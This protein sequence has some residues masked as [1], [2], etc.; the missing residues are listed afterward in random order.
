MKYY[1]FNCQVEPT[2]EEVGGK[3]KSLIELTK[4]GFEVPKGAVL[5][6]DFFNEW[7]DELR[8]G[9]TSALTWTD[10]ESFPELADRLKRKAED[11]EFS[12]EQ[13]TVIS[14]VI[15]ELDGGGLFAVRSSSPEEDMAGASFAGGY[16]TVLGV[17]ETEIEDAVKLAFL[18]CLDKRVFYYKHQSG[19]DTSQVR[20]AVII[21]EQIASDASGVG[22]SLNPMNNAYDEAVINANT[23]LGESVVSGLVTPDEY[24]V[25]KNT[26]QMISVKPGSKEKAIVLAVGGG[27]E[28]VEGMKGELSLSEKQVVELTGLIAEVESSYGFPVDI[29]W[30]F[31]NDRLYLLQSR[32]VTTYIPLPEEMQT[33][34]GEQKVLYIDGSLTKQGITT[35]IS[36]MGCDAIEIT[37]GIMF[38]DMMGK[39]TTED[40][41]WGLAA[42]RGGRMYVNAS[43]SMR[44]QGKKRIVNMW[45]TVDVVTARVLEELDLEEYIPKK[46]P[47][48]L[49]GAMWGTVKNNIGA[50]KYMRQAAKDPDGYKKWYQPFEDEFDSYL[51]GIITSGI[52]VRQAPQEIFSRFIDLLG[53]ML[54]MTYAAELARKAIAKQL[55]KSFPDDADLM[56]YLE[57]SLPDNVTIDMGLMMYELA[58]MDEVASNDEDEICRIIDEKAYSK[59]FGNLWQE[60]VDTYGCRTTNEL[61]VGVA[62]SYEKVDVIAAQLKSMASV[63]DEFSPKRIYEESRQLREQTYDRICSGLQGSD[64]RKFKRKYNT[65]VKLGGKREALKYWYVRSLTAIRELLLA[66]ADRLV[67][68]GSLRTGKM[69]SDCISLNSLIRTV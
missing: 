41:K 1:F 46:L 32:P 45:K 54:P 33:R 40:I 30:A 69:Y 28:T 52:A 53:K 24:V 68:K 7:I 37:Q 29:E 38:T 48:V 16:E 11:F 21:Q 13:R 62:R 9:E 4:K 22:F 47:E 66:E 64:L 27:T 18:S 19:F 31:A 58:V 49:K 26:M 12:S 6:V 60:F 50:V 35:P 15:G 51:S 56:K 44:F 8:R 63:E 59:T 5:T 57:R 43:S 23:G 42:T 34:V 14:Q 2:L 3:A 36:V 25:D 61:D 65:L 20:I 55:E 67:E 10:P 39:D 17:A